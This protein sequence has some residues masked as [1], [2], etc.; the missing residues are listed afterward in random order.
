MEKLESYSEQIEAIKKNMVKQKVKIIS[1]RCKGWEGKLERTEN[2]GKRKMICVY[3][4][5]PFQQGLYW[6]DVKR[7]KIKQE[8]IK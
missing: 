3:F 5:Y 6:F 1:G 7:V 8:K 2:W 4:T